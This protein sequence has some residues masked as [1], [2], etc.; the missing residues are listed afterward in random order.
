M[1]KLSIILCAALLA[2]TAFIVS[3]KNSVEYIDVSSQSYTDSYVVTGTV[4]FT[5]EWGN[6]SDNT[7][8]QKTVEKFS[9]GNAIVSRTVNK[10]KKSN[11]EDYYSIQLMGN[12]EYETTE[13]KKVAGTEKDPVEYKGGSSYSENW[14]N[15]YKV[16]GVWYLDSDGDYVKVDEFTI[17]GKAK[18][19]G[20]NKTESF[21]LKFKDNYE[22][23]KAS[24]D[25]SVNTNVYEYDLT[26]TK[27]LK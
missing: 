13:I 18:G 23:R 6:D 14:L 20:K 9:A 25:K 3:C 2:G 26:F 12:Y 17:G 1:K 15:L 5:R 22:Q 11:Y 8:K 7:T 24:N 16:D 27:G 10:N 21:T 19:K 4:T